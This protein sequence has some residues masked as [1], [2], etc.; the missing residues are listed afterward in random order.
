MGINELMAIIGTAGGIE[1]LIQAGKWWLS[2]KAARRQ[3]E[4]DAEAAENENGRKQIDW[5]EKRLSERDAKID[6][7][8]NELRQEQNARIEEIHRRHE[9][10]LMLAEAEAKKCHKRGCV[11]RIPPS[12]Y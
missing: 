12:D 9:I 7:L 5:L 3:D 6:G 10:E 1:G 8:Y 4:A 2:R 11:D